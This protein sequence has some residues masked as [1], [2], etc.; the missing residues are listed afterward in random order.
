MRGL[1]LLC[2]VGNNMRDFKDRETPRYVSERELE[3][4]QFVRLVVSQSDQEVAEMACL[5]GG[6]T[7][8]T[9]YY[10]AGRVV[11]L[12]VQS[13]ARRRYIQ[14]LDSQ[15]RPKAFTPVEAL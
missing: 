6:R 12:M 11:G 10:K 14:I 3:M 1:A 13:H 4:H 2:L 8:T 9:T 7:T 5:D 15:F